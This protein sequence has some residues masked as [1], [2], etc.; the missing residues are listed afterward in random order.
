MTMIP[1]DQWAEQYFDHAEGHRAEPPCLCPWCTG[2]W[3]ADQEG[4]Q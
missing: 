4:T 1:D 3:K 2:K